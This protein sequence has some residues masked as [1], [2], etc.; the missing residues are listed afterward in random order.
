[1]Q[2]TKDEGMGQGMGVSG[3]AG[4]LP[5]SGCLVPNGPRMLSL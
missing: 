4:E 5:W 1:M 3:D 2:G